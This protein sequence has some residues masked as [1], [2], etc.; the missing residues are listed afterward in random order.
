MIEKFQK[1]KYIVDFNIDL[2]EP[3]FVFILTIFL[4]YIRFFH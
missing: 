4:M 3:Y 2:H 1:E